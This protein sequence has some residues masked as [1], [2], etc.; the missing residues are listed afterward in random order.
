MRARVLQE[1]ATVPVD[2]FRQAKPTGYEEVDFGKVAEIRHSISE[3]VG[4]G[5]RSKFG[6]RD[7]RKGGALHKV[8]LVR[9]MGTKDAVC[10]A[11][12]CTA[13]R[14]FRFDNTDQIDRVKTAARFFRTNV[15]KGRAV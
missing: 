5:I 6:D 10:G 11:T 13:K 3:N 15:C 4:R 2:F 7:G 14:A 12:E 1:R 9:I 8:V